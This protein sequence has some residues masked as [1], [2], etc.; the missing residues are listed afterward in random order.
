MLLTFDCY[1]TLIDWETGIREA[2][3]HAFPQS[4]ALA[5][6]TLGSQF[7]ALQNRLK[8][9]R[10]RTYRTLLTEGGD[11]AGGQT[12]LGRTRRGPRVASPTRFLPGDRSTTPIVRWCD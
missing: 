2:L 4:A 3:H 9:D 12:W 5:D 1:G 8:T 10:Y 11:R 7:H 6:E